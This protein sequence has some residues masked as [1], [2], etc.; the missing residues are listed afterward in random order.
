MGLA[1]LWIPPGP[2]AWAPVDRRGRARRPWAMVWCLGVAILSL[3]ISRGADGEPD[4]R[5][6]GAPCWPWGGGQSPGREAGVG[7]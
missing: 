3:I 6:S 4:S 5:G 2:S 7:W 1:G